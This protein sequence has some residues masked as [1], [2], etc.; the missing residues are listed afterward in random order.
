VTR[1]TWSL[2]TLVLAVVVLML[3]GAMTATALLRDDGGE[4]LRAAAAPWRSDDDELTRLHKEVAAAARAETLAF[5]AVDYRGMDPIMDRVLE[6]A[7]GDFAEQYEA[8]LED[9][10]EQAVANRTISTA[11]VVALGVAD[12]DAESALVYVAAD[13]EVQS[14]GTGGKAQPRYHRLQLDM[15]R[16]GSEW[17]ASSVQ[18]VG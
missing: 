3:G 9:L 12:L 6:G 1:R 13:S 16:E 11:T 2:T 7:T 17:L 5:L 4:E 14:K 10:K 18:F 15:V 8:S